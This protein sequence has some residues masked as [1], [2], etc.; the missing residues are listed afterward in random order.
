[1]L[2]IGAT[3]QPDAA[4]RERA[5]C[6]ALAIASAVARF[7]QLSGT[8]QLP[9]RIGLHAGPMLLG[10][11]GALDHYEYRAVGDIVNTASRIEGL[12][13]FLRTQ[14][15][16][17]AEVLQQLH[18][19]LT[20][21]LGTFLVVGKSQPLVVHELLCRL[22]NAHEQQRNLCALFA[23]AL[24][25]YRGQRWEEA[26]E[27]FSELITSSSS[28]EDGPSLFYVQLCEQYREKPPGAAWD[29]VVHMLRK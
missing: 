26:I 15:L 14:I 7:K 27:K 1:M 23:E 6:A 16:V 25:A 2:A 21:E 3:A 24:G 5:C 19:F 18:G 10:N 9:T 20:R 22:E 11:I 28:T 17:S 13:K 8:V 29:G 4:L 12:N